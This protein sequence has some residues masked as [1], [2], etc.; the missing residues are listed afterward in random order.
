[1]LKYIAVVAL[2]LLLMA[3]MLIALHF[4]GY[5]RRPGSCGCGSRINPRTLRN[6][7]N[8]NSLSTCRNDGPAAEEDCAC[9]Q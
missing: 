6:R 9:N 3:F 1:M 8:K 5:K 7:N 4:S 2:F